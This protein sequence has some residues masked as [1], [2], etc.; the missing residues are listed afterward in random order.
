MKD[1]FP[2]SAQVNGNVL[3]IGGYPLDEL[4]ERFGTPLYVLDEQ[5]LRQNAR[6]YRD[7][8]QELY[9]GDSLPIFASKALCLQAVFAILHKE[10]FGLDVVSAG[11]LHTAQSIDYEAD[12]IFFH[13]N[14]KSK[15]E[16]V[17]ICQSGGVKPV[18]DNFHEISL[19]AEINEPIQALI[20]VTP[21]V[22]CHTH[23]YI[24]TGHLE[25]KFG[26]DPEQLEKAIDL[27]LKSGNIEL[28]GLHCHIGSQ[29][30]EIEPYR[31]AVR[32]MFEKYRDLRDRYGLM[33]PILNL[34]GGMG[35]SYTEADDPPALRALIQNISSTVQEF[36][37]Q[38]EI[39]LPRLILEPGRSIVGR[40]GVTV[41]R[42]GSSKQVPGGKHYLAVDG[43]MADNPR[44]ITYQAEYS[45]C[46]I[47][48][49][50]G[51]EPQA[52][53]DLAGRYCE[54]G[55]ILI[56]DLSLA[57]NA[58]AGDLVA[59]FGTG[60]YNYSMSSN[61]NRVGRPAMVLVNDGEAEQILKRETLDDLLE[62]DILP[63]RLVGLKKVRA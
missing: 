15:E 27:V 55:D 43:G 40:A 1:Y 47:R 42:I 16:L 62:N 3:A 25:S 6:A 4:A 37:R 22:E 14:N 8:L 2:E 59:V 48:D 9:P 45:A 52:L 30:F 17:M 60:A 5:T 35:I 28:I 51:K 49:P 56:K 10:G 54:S 24:K 36:A 34:G 57:A 53:Y 50:E 32:F 38:Y 21:G 26:F 13:G 44:S 7:L 46:L 18:I 58:S 11:E 61:Y 23:E 39:P 63:S 41:Y 31:E 12:K 33:L 20:R 29:I 19:L